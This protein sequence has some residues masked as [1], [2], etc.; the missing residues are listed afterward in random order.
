[1]RFFEKQPL[2]FPPGLWSAHH[3]QFLL[4]SI[5]ALDEFAQPGC[6]ACGWLVGSASC[7]R[8]CASI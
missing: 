5:Q 4:Q 8:A 3:F 2:S 6:S 7:S 1:M